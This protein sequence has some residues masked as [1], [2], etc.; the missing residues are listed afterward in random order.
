MISLS[1][2]VV[3][4]YM[5]VYVNPPLSQRYRYQSAP[6]P[7]AGVYIMSTSF[8][9]CLRASTTPLVCMHVQHALLGSRFSL[10]LY[11]SC[12]VSLA[13]L[14]VCSRCACLVVSCLVYSFL[15]PSCL[16]VSCRPFTFRRGCVHGSTNPKNR[17]PSTRRWRESPCPVPSACAASCGPRLPSARIW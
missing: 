12:K 15:I 16:V 8:P 9:L 13:F 7:R 3:S 4:E 14:H 5:C 1:V 17:Q 2:K 10:S 11:V 6:P